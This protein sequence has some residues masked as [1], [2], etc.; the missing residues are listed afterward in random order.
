MR[1]K[2]V[3]LLP[4]VALV[5]FACTPPGGTP[6]SATI[7]LKLTNNQV[8]T[9]ATSRSAIGQTDASGLLSYQVAITSIQLITDATITGTGLDNPQQTLTL[10]ENPVVI[11][12]STAADPATQGFID[13]LDSTALAGFTHT[14]TLTTADAGV[15]QYLFITYAPYVRF[16]AQV[17]LN[18]SGAT[19]LYSKAGGT[20]INST[21]APVPST[22]QGWFTDNSGADFSSAPSALATVRVG[23]GGS[24]MKFAK[25]L[26]ITTDDLANG[27]QLKLMLVFDPVG[28]ITAA[29]RN[30]VYAGGAFYD[31]NLNGFDV[32]IP[33]LGALVS[34]VGKTVVMETYTAT[35]HET[36]SDLISDRSNSVNAW[37]SQWFKQRIEIYS[38]AEDPGTILS[39][40]L[41][42]LIE[43]SSKLS[44]TSTDWVAPP[45][46]YSPMY[47][48]TTDGKLSLQ[49]YNHADLV[50]GLARL[51]SVGQTGTAAF[52]YETSMD[53]N[54]ATG[55]AYS[56][57][58]PKTDTLTY[59]LQEIRTLPN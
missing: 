31:M 56:T 36:K 9:S 29:E 37:N 23:S 32:P 1:A 48:T 27:V 45:P 35:I 25:P 14:H 30:G 19:K 12:D 38:L 22:G 53:P 34:T 46:V 2:A 47:F 50:G 49:D 42:N 26:T 20:F 39:V 55:T 7:G 52:T 58:Q 3:F 40:Q 11:S 8:M 16:N 24:F 51:N 33:S 28:A 10:Y 13:L 6:T 59:T 43:P 54:P 41:T 17:S 57:L 18:G 44:T 5:F 21:T 15:Y 4:F